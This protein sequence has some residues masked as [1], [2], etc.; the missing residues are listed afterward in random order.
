MSDST[1]PSM[2][3]AARRTTGK[4]RPHQT[5]N[6]ALVFEKS[7]PGKRGYKLAPLDV[8]RSRYQSLARRRRARSAG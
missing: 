7:A 8:P 6:E 3:G 2:N 4:V 5:Q 1:N